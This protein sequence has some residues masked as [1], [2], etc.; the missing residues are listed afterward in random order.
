MLIVGSGYLGFLKVRR[1]ASSLAFAEQTF[2]RAEARLKSKPA[3]LLKQQNLGSFIGDMVSLES[4]LTS[5]KREIGFLIPLAE[6]VGQLPALYE[7]KAAAVLLDAAVDVAAGMRLAGEGMV[8]LAGV[9]GDGAPV[10]RDDGVDPRVIA[11]LEAG[12]GDFELAE[13]KLEAAIHRLEVLNRS[14]LGGNV[15]KTVSRLDK[16]L[17]A[18]QAFVKFG[19]LGPDIIRSLLGLDRPKRYLVISQNNEELRATGGFIG[20][21]WLVGLHR[22]K[23]VELDFKDSADADDLSKRYPPPPAAISKYLWGGVWLFR[24]ANWSPDFPTSARL[25]AD[26]YKLGQDVSVDGVIAIDQQAL[27]AIL[28]V[29]G[30]IFVRDFQ[31]WVD[32]VNVVDKMVSAS[33]AVTSPGFESIRPKKLFMGAL[34]QELLG[35]FQS[36]VDADMLMK[37]VGAMGQKLGEKHLLA[38][39]NDE[40]VQSL[41]RESHQDGAIRPSQADYLMVVDSNV[42]YRKINARVEQSINYEV[43]LE[44]G[45][46]ARGKVTISYKNNSAEKVT[47][48]IQDTIRGASYER[49]REGCYW[50]YLRVYVTKGAALLQASNIPMPKGSF[51]S[52]LGKGREGNEAS[53]ASPEGGKEVFDLFFDV[54]PGASRE[55]FFAYSLP[56]SVVGGNSGVKK[57]ELLVQKQP[58]TSSIPLQVAVNLPQG[59]KL[60]SSEPAPKRVTF[61]RV[62]F[63]A[64]LARDQRFVVSFSME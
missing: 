28:S 38:Y 62:D 13:K 64:S 1:V 56:A 18:L 4:A 16:G 8:P 3:E 11:A 46:A 23:V 63:Q 6:A 39:F 22:G 25:V 10:F 57:Y 61:R 54:A 14:E 58:G 43:S 30:P 48:C 19:H 2:S 53:T 5:L 29:T 41:L 15:S 37:L 35:K 45:G 40:V 12:K 7:A 32:A 36:G 42:A 26:F 24:D 51:W 47:E 55:V 27:E 49:W 9:L 44:R 34:F 52:R 60:I 50:D 59:A 31:E 33:N 21:V 20:G 17:P